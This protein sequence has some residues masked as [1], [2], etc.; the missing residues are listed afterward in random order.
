MD[1]KFLAFLVILRL[2]KTIFLQSQIED[3]DTNMV[4]M[5]VSTGVFMVLEE[6]NNLNR[7]LEV[8]TRFV[9]LP[10]RS[11]FT[12][13]SG[14]VREGEK[15]LTVNLM[16]YYEDTEL[17][18]FLANGA[19]LL[20]ELLIGLVPG[21]LI[22]PIVST[23]VIVVSSQGHQSAVLALTGKFL[24]SFRRVDHP[25][26]LAKLLTAALK[27]KLIAK[28][29]GNDPQ[30]AQHVQQFVH[31]FHVDLFEK[32][33]RLSPDLLRE[34]PMLLTPILE[35][36]RLWTLGKVE[37]V[38]VPSITENN[39]QNCV[40]QNISQNISPNQVSPLGPWFDWSV[41]NCVGFLDR[42]AVAD[43]GGKIVDED[44]EPGSPMRRRYLD[45][46]Y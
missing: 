36:V 25:I 8:L 16:D 14:G 28:E 18:A 42:A 20:F 34:D 6:T 10:V 27:H 45:K 4:N 24:G 41:E 17:D 21:L 43:S 37:V 23:N 19:S 12:A 7:L 26:F 5:K 44:S 46:H 13:Q 15:K 39:N 38:V 30:K 3:P 31:L 1:R 32:I 40:G 35:L 9:S 2:R 33:N 29:S 22:R 11:V